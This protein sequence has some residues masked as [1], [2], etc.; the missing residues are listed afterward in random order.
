M[1]PE[2]A[3]RIAFT[4]RIRVKCEDGDQNCLEVPAGPFDVAARYQRTKQPKNQ[5]EPKNQNQRTKTTKEPRQPYLI[6][7]LQHPEKFCHGASAANLLSWPH[8]RA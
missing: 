6:P 1:R 4:F 5:K 3:V 7:V 2:A 8:A